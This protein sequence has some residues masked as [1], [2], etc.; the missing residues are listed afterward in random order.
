MTVLELY[1]EPLAACFTPDVALRIVEFR[2][3]D[4]TEARLEYL[5]ERANDGAITEPERAEYQ[6]FVEAIDFVGLLKA[7]ARVALDASRK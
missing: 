7:R 5:R 4:V 6:E 1:L 3:D 2:P